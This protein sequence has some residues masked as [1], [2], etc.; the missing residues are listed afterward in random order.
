MPIIAVAGGTSNVGRT[1]VDAPIAD[2]KHEVIVL[3]RNDHKVHTLISAIVMRTEENGAAEVNLIEAAGA[4]QTTKRMVSSDWA[5]P[6][7]SPDSAEGQKH[8][9][10][11][12]KNLAWKALEATTCLQDRTIFRC[13]VWL[14]YYVQHPALI[15]SHFTPFRLVVDTASNRAAIPGDGNT[16]V[17]FI[18][19]A[20]LRPMTWNEFIA[21]AEEVKGTK[22]GVVYDEVAKLERFEVTELPSHVYVYQAIPKPFLQGFLAAFGLWFARGLYD[23]DEANALEKRLSAVK[24]R[25]ARE[26]FE[27]AW[28][29]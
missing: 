18:H 24:V 20:D 7:P 4:S 23:L 28:R 19:A 29:T 26:L 5:A 3:S 1:I 22:F 8:P 21:L 14:D 27:M 12:L 13:G 9:A 25:T 2:G 17:S 15:K 16:K 11:K 6:M 10:A